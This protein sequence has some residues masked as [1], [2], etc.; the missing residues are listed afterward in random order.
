MDWTRSEIAAYA[1]LAVSLGSFA[2]AGLALWRGIDAS[3]PKAWLELLPT[4]SPH[5]WQATI[6]LRNLSLI[7]IRLVSVSVDVVEVPAGKKQDLLLDAPTL[8]EA[9]PATGGNMK[10]PIPTTVAAILPG[11]TGSYSFLYKRALLRN[12]RSVTLSVGVKSL[13]SQPRHA[14]INVRQDIPGGGITIGIASSA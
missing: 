12:A 6:Y 13:H 14:R 4:A 11:E 3:R 8:D 2:I 9:G 1:A 5:V 10:M 7:P